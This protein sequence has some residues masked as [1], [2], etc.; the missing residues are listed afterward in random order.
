MKKS[1]M[2]L[3]AAAALTASAFAQ[4]PTGPMI[5]E[6]KE[7]QQ[8]RIA[9]GVNN[10]SLT[11]GEAARLEHKEARINREERAYRAQNGGRLTPSERRHITR[12]QNRESRRIYRA[13][14]NGWHR[15]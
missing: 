9:N 4:A 11:P 3:A 10:G 6:R 8:Q 13:K 2:I 1:M 12:Q 15:Y 14:H 7:V 5:H